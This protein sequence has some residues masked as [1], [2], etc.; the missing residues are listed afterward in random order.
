MRIAFL[1]NNTGTDNGW[2]RFSRELIAAVSRLPGIT[3]SVFTEEKG[4]DFPNEPVLSGALRFSCQNSIF[5]LFLHLPKL[6]SAARRLKRNI[7]NA[8]II[9]AL[10]GYP[11][12]AIGALAKESRHRLV[13]TLQGSYALTAFSYPLERRLFRYGLSQAG[14]VTAIS[15]FTRERFSYFVPDIDPVVIGHGT[16]SLFLSAPRST[17][18]P[19]VASPY[20]LSVGAV[21]PQKGYSISLE[22]F[23]RV[24]KRFTDLHYV[25]VGHLG[26]R[27]LQDVRARIR[28]LTIER[29]VHFFERLTDAELISLYDHAELFILTPRTIGSVV[30]GFG[31]VY[32]EAGAR[33]LTVVGSRDCGAEDAIIDGKTGILV[34][35]GD[36]EAVRNAIETLLADPV[37]RRRMGEEG[38]KLAREWTWDRVAREY[39]K[40]YEGVLAGSEIH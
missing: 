13:I 27:H 24:R 23:A 37:M 28:E 19:L 2:G 22:A 39:K 15:R 38:R 14:A 10:D 29:Q 34:P 36:A 3:V 12:G 32:R 6:W 21:K 33:G 9:H 30:E 1:T 20:L 5:S 31:L 18:P 17:N 7:R 40:V 4:R 26:D 25:I 35:Q 8:D 11:Y 16:P